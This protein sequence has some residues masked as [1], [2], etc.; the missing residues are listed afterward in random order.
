[1]KPILFSLGVIAL[2]AYWSACDK[3]P[4][5]DDTPTIEFNGFSA[6]TVQQWSGTID[7]NI[8][9]TDGDGDL[10]GSPDT[11]SDI[12][13]VDTRRMDT[14]YY[15]IPEIPSDPSAS[16]GIFGEITVRVSQICCIDPNFPVI[17][18][19]IPD[20]YDET[21]FKIRIRDRAGRWSNE[22]ETTPLRIRCY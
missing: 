14:L 16:L 22:V 18:S 5:Y 21:T 8:G 10:G 11:V 13:L 19:T 1:M 2:A 6:D 9:F 15:R 3:P 7:F 4:I 20:T 12:L 17:C